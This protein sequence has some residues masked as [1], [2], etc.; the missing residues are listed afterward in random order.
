MQATITYNKTGVKTVLKGIKIVQYVSGLIQFIG[1]DY[2]FKR[3]FPDDDVFVDIQHLEETEKFE[4]SKL[5]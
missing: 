3:V 1:E 2:T 5:E 4:E